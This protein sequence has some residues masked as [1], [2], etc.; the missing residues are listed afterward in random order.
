MELVVE[1]CDFLA[2]LWDPVWKP[3]AGYT[4]TVD[5]LRLVSWSECFLQLWWWSCGCC[6]LNYAP[7]ANLIRLWWVQPG[8]DNADGRGA[9]FLPRF[10]SIVDTY[11]TLILQSYL[12][13]RPAFL[14]P[15]GRH[16][17]AYIWSFPCVSN[18]FI[19]QLTGHFYPSCP[20]P[21]FVCGGL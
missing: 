20:L 10:G 18:N 4:A 9:C 15:L 14:I 3:A 1:A 12:H 11:F 6:I 19:Y 7:V 8:W 13:V 2:P 5:V 17:L 21:L 16:C